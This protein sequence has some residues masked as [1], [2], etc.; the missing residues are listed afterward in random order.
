MILYSLDDVRIALN[1]WLVWDGFRSFV[2]DVMFLIS[3]VC[4]GGETVLCSI[5]VH[6]I[7]RRL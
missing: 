1:V 7:G 5:V 4:D 2:I 3:S 6:G